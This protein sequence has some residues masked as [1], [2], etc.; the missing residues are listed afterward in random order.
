VH[1][2][3][4]DSAILIHGSAKQSQDLGLLSMFARAVNEYEPR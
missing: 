4:N 1:D 3:W 2:R